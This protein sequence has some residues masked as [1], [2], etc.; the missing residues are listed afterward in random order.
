MDDRPTTACRSMPTRPPTIRA[1]I[2]L[3]GNFYVELHPGTPEAPILLRRDAAGRRNV[4][5]GPAR[6]R[7][8][9]ARRQRSREP[10]DARAGSRRSRLTARPRAA[11]DAGQ[12][13]T[14]RGLTGAQAL[15]EP[16]SSTPPAR[17]RRSAIVN[18]AL[19]ARPR[20][21]R[22]RRVRQ[23]RGV[24]RAGLQPA[25]LAD[26]VDALRRRRRRAR[27]SPAGAGA[28]LAAFRRC[29]APP[30]A[31]T[32]RSTPRS[33]RRSSSRAILPGIRQLGPTI[34][35]ALPWIAQL[36]ALASRRSSATAERAGAG[37]Q[38][39]LED[40]G[41]G[42]RAAAQPACGAVHGSHRDPDGNE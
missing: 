30:P 38:G 33:R 11:Q 34:D 18:Q 21:S 6:P 42:D 40:V 14:S 5:T 23:P 22:R 25:K 39:H 26:L 8:V 20:R 41:P 32:A 13:P 24:R 12:D 1:R 17:S 27:R 29:C 35:A 19:L 9:R 15:N 3:E 37:G 31:P 4:R 10:A 16:R 2:F 36:T 28:D 7:P